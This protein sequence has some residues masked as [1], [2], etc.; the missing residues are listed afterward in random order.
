MAA[1]RGWCTWSFASKPLSVRV[2]CRGDI[3]PLLGAGWLIL[4]SRVTRRL[5]LFLDR[6]K[7]G[8]AECVAIHDDSC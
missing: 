3:G 8:M 7:V 1:N 6:G 2:I 4:A 5:P